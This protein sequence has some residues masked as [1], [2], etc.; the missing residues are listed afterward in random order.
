[1]RKVDF[2]IDVEF[3]TLT[4]RQRGCGPFAYT[5]HGEHRG[6]GKRRREE[7]AGGV[8]EVMFGKQKLSVG[9][10]RGIQFGPRFSTSRWKSFSRTHTGIAI[11]KERMHRIS[12]QPPASRA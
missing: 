5:V 10:K 2:A 6:F 1:M 12:T 4:H 3:V 9:L 7:C 8:A 11:A